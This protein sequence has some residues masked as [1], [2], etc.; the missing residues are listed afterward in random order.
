MNSIKKERLV[1]VFLISVALIITMIISLPI[2]DSY[3]HDYKKFWIE[4]TDAPSDYNVVVIGDSR[5]YRGISPDAMETVLKGEKVLNFGYSSA[6]LDNLLLKKASE[7]LINDG[8]EKI[9]VLGITPNSLTEIPNANADLLDNIQM[10]R[11]DKYE[12][13]Y[14]Y[15]VLKYFDALDLDHIQN[16]WTTSKEPKN[17]IEE[18]HSNGWIASDYIVED[19]NSAMPGYRSWFQKNMVSQNMIN[20]LMTQV[21]EWSRQGIK[22]YGFRFPT[23]YSMVQLEDSLSGFNEI[24]FA[25]NFTKMGGKWLE[26]SNSDFH[27]YDGS[28]LEKQSA[29]IF[30]KQLALKI[31]EGK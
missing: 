18:F 20:R 7:K 12:I 22:V 8:S 24:V 6:R 13:L 30:S 29:E 9:I 21:G 31:K 1:F 17:Y 23:S 28:H 16:A 11:E 27:S 15:D 14:F 26:F 10:P 4:K 5:I 19:T 3:K 2:K 25:Q